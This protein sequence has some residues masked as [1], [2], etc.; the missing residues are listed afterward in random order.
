MYSF[1]FVK[2]NKYPK[3]REKS[4]TCLKVD[5]TLPFDHNEVSLWGL[6]VPHNPKSVLIDIL[7]L[8]PFLNLNST[9]V[10][11]LVGLEVIEIG[12]SETGLVN[13]SQL[14]VLALTGVKKVHKLEFLI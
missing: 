6:E 8:A 4:S 5:L 1:F 12:G 9:F 10:G 11:E 7:F 2:Q 14:V 13:L 3:T